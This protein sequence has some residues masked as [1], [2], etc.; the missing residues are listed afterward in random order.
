MLDQ[1]GELLH[2]PKGAFG[3][4]EGT[5]TEQDARHRIVYRSSGGCAVIFSNCHQKAEWRAL[6]DQVL[7]EVVPNIQA[8][9]I[10]SAR[11]DGRFYNYSQSVWHTPESLAE[12]IHDRISRRIFVDGECL[13]GFRFQDV[14][15][16]SERT[17]EGETAYGSLLFLPAGMTP[18]MGIGIQLTCGEKSRDVLFQPPQ[19]KYVR[20]LLAGCGKPGGREQDRQALVFVQ[21]EDSGASKEHGKKS[22]Y[23]CFGFVPEKEADRFPIRARI[24]GQGKWILS[25]SGQDVLQFKNGQVRFIR[26]PIEESR[27]SLEQELGIC[28]GSQRKPGDSPC[29]EDYR[30]FIEVLSRQQHGTSAIFLDLQH[31]AVAGRMRDLE[32]HCRAQR[33]EPWSVLKIEPDDE[34]AGAISGISRIDGCFIVD[35]TKGTLEFINVI[36][37]GQAVVDGSMASGSRRNSIPAFLANLVRDCPGTKA[38][39]F[40]FSEDGDLSVIRG[41]DMERQLHS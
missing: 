10:Q 23:R 27:E 19:L 34:R 18:P 3:Y 29:F 37:D 26:D 14:A 21:D 38:V 13:F 24:H 33:V 16:L 36:V 5:C 17:Y 8:D 12:A 22:C 11:G 6:A 25:L 35:Y 28:L 20:K 1:L 40:L 32:A 9:K 2:A 15:N 4:R 41:S 39:A 30:Q 7:D 31:P